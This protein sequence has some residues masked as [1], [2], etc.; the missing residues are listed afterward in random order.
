[1]A[2][3]W[4]LGYSVAQSRRET[5]RGSCK[6]DRQASKHLSDGL[7]ERKGKGPDRLLDLR[8]AQVLDLFFL[9]NDNINNSSCS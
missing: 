2:I 1:M 5:R 3:D 7:I 9:I 4:V 6:G 8:S